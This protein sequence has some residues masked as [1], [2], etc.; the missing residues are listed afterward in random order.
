MELTRPL[1]TTF[2][3]DVLFDEIVAAA[4]SNYG[5][6]VLNLRRERLRSDE[7]IE[8]VL[9]C[10]SGNADTVLNTVRDARAEYPAAK[11]VLLGVE[12]TDGEVV[13]LIEKG[14]TAFVARTE[15]LARLVD[16]LEMVRNN[17][18]ICSARITRLV[19]DNIH[20][21]SRQHNAYGQIQL[22]LREIEILRLISD[23]LSNKEIASHLCIAPNTVKNHV[24]HLLEKL[25]VS[26][27]HEAAYR[28]SHLLR[29]FPVAQ[30]TRQIRLPLKAD[31]ELRVAEND[32]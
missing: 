18:T 23:G 14:V 11:L 7:R 13:R 25:K 15:G 26:S 19:V 1:L 4:L 10:S 21:L 30:T 3:L 29:N 9:A 24:H 16:T 20:R 32:T 17:R 31:S 6:R 8:I 12:G 2:G 5:W 22:T 28:Q 27:R